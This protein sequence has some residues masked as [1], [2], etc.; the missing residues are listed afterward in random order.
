MFILLLATIPTHKFKP[1]NSEE[2][3][4]DIILSYTAETIEEADL[5]MQIA[6]DMFEE[7]AKKIG[8]TINVDKTKCMAFKTGKSQTPRLFL[9]NQEIEAVDEYKY[10]GVT[11]DA[12]WLTWGKHIKDLLNSCESIIN[13][14]KSMAFSKYGADR[15]TLLLLYT[16]L[17]RSKIL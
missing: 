15:K 14:M 6:I 7:W 4:D 2:F 1:V 5:H 11:F 8:L 3:A 12:P 9:N 13:L 17:I 16:S 10:L